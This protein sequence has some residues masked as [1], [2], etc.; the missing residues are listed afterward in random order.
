MSTRE[1]ATGLE[2]QPE[3]HSNEPLRPLIQGVLDQV[4][5]CSIS[6]IN[7]DGTAHISTA[8]Y[9]VDSVWKMYF[10]SKQES[11]H[12]RNIAIRPSVAVAVYD[13]TQEWDDWKTGLQIAGKCRLAVGHEIRL[14]SSLYK[15]RFP[16][17]SKWLH[18]IGH[19]LNMASVPP[20]Y[21]V[22]SESI[23]LLSEEILGEEKFVSVSLSRDPS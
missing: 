20:F 7:P 13:S 14:A 23:K 18:S 16:G 1:S 15:E 12:S 11:Q 3:S 9:C 17:Y 10:V 21:V 6:T 2:L 19:T 4:H 8:F 22:N 5:L